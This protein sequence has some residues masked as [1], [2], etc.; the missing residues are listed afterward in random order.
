MTKTELHQF[1]RTL[2]K[3]QTALGKGSMSR[4][5]LAIEASLDELDRIQHASERDHATGN[6]ER[7]SIRLRECGLH[8]AASVRVRLESVSAAKT[9][10]IRSVLPAVPWTSCCIVCQEAVDRGQNTPSTRSTNR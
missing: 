3:S 6:L 4:E 2:E 5:A 9:T 10:L 8:F 1:R 7:N